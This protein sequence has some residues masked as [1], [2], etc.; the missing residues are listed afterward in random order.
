MAKLNTPKVLVTVSL[1]RRTPALR[2]LVGHTVRKD[3]AGYNHNRSECP[4]CQAGG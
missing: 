3:G 4:R 1:A 2:E